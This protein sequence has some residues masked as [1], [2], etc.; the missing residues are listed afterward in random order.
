MRLWKIAWRSIQQRALASALTALSMAMGV[1]LVVAVIVIH[2]VIDQSFRR[3]AQG[4]ELI[5]GAKGSPLE[6]VLTSVYHLGNASGTIPY[7]V[8]D[9]LVNGTDF[10]AD[11]EFAVPL[12]MGDNFKGFRVIGTTP[13]MFDRL[14]YRDGQKYE[15]ADGRNFKE[16][17]ENEAVIGYAASRRT[18]LTVGTEFKPVH[19]S[20][21]ERGEEHSP[22]RIVGVLAPTGTPNDKAIFVNMEG[23]YHIHTKSADDSEADS[24]AKKSAAHHDSKADQKTEAKLPG[25]GETADKTKAG[26]GKKEMHAAKSEA[27]H[28]HES[29]PDEKKQVSAV[30]VVVNENSPGTRK[31]ALPKLINKTLDA[32]AVAPSEQIDRLLGGVVGDIQKILLILAVLIV[33][34]AGIGIMVSI[35][36]SMSDRRHEIAIIRAL[37]ARRSTIMAVVLLES[38]LL[39]LGGGAIGLL[40]G[41]G[42]TGVLAPMIAD[43]TGVSVNPLQFQFSELILIPG[44]ILLASMVGY[45]PAVVAYRTDVAQSL[46]SSP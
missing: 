27:G 14:E 3:G 37:G 30:L 1:A 16:D 35:Y 11:V 12:C 21:A 34:V 18:G 32:Q 2:G 23:F 22:F 17:A 43:K 29:I 45:L 26:E 8:Y 19:G 9:E 41:H 28:A 13:A 40:L 42:L 33:V 7:S 15:F 20:A 44:L 31:V 10:A 5:V 25:L 36:N 24:A 6:L 4:Y 39:A 38:I 46:V